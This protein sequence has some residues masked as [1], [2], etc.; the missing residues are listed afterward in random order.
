VV[1]ILG[2]PCRHQLHCSA[3][4]LKTERTTAQFDTTMIA[5]KCLKIFFTLH[6]AHYAPRIQ[7]VDWYG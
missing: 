1:P 3:M 2:P 5:A 6:H 4:N 7:S